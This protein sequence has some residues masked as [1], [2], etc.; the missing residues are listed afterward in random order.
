MAKFNTTQ[1]SRLKSQDGDLNSVDFPYVAERHSGHHS[2]SSFYV[3]IIGQKPAESTHSEPKV[4]MTTCSILCPLI[5]SVQRIFLLRCLLS[6]DHAG[7]L[8]PP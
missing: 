3:F 2:H 8:V 5:V 7:C 1:R 6:S 4:L